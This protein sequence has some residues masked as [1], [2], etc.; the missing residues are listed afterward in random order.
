MNML[1]GYHAAGNVE[2]APARRAAAD[3]D[4]VI[5]LREQALHAVDALAETRFGLEAEDVA[6]LLVENGFGQTKFR[7]LRPHHAAG[8]RILVVD[9]DFV[10]KRQQ[11]T[12]DGE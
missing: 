4:R 5:F 8:E 11:V 12:R 6:A 9:H 1:G 2:I 10:A 3:E 7:N